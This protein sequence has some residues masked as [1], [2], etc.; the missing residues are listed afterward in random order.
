MDVFGTGRQEWHLAFRGTAFNQQSVYDAYL[1]GTE[2][3]SPGCK[4]ISDITQSCNE[5]YR[6]SILNNWKDIDEVAF[7]V[8][9][10]GMVQRYA[11]F[12]GHGTDNM[13][14]FSQDKLRS[15]NWPD[16]MSQS[17]HYFGITGDHVLKRHFFINHNYGGCHMDAGW[18]VAV[19]KANP[20]CDWEKEEGFP[21]FMYSDSDVFENWTKGKFAK[22]DAIAVYVKYRKQDTVKYA[23][24]FGDGKSEW[25]LVFRGASHINE[26]IYKGYQDGIQQVD[27]ACLQLNGDIPCSSHYR[28]SV[29]DD[30][31]NIAEVAFTFYKSG[32]L[33]TYVI[34]D[35]A[36]SDNVNWFTQARMRSSSWTDI[37]GH[38][39][40]LSI[41]G[42][43]NMERHFFI[44]HNYGGCNAD[45]GWTI[46]VDQ[47]GRPCGWESTGTYPLFL[48]SKTT[49]HENWTNGQIAEADVLAIFVKF[50]AQGGI[51][52]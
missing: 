1:T 6:S 46:A 16:L 11:T 38:A 31:K 4:Q 12:Y 32:Q 19:D 51:I 22:A 15:S 7:V 26:S 14:W 39:Q 36:G 30:W 29:L 9:R 18:F 43:G 37:K 8:V 28:S 10:N 5:H 49:H 52:G 24:V 33:K 45:S 17:H 41:I 2:N 50:G 44:N 35:G 27:S 42:D 34:F 21:I 23:D 47:H 3:V 25:R 13:N 48:Y 40:F 20:P